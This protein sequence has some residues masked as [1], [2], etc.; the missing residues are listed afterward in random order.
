[1]TEM[2]GGKA[3]AADPASEPSPARTAP[4]RPH[5][6]QAHPL[7]QIALAA[8]RYGLCIAA[9]AWLVTHVPW[10][11]YIQVQDPAIGRI[12]LI[13]ETPE[14]FLVQAADGARRVLTPAEAKTVSVGGLTV[15]DIEYGIPSVVLRMNRQ[16]A[17]L[18]I[19]IFLPVPILSAQRLI[20]ML[21]IQDVRLSLWNSVKLT[22]VGNFFNFALPGTTG[23]DLIK[24]YYL[25]R[26]THRK[27]EA[28]TTIFL[29]RIIGL[30]GLVLLAGALMVTSW[31]EQ[32]FGA[33]ARPLLLV[34]AVLALGATFIFSE[35]M[36]TWLR[37]GDLVRALPAGIGD[38]VRRVGLA[39]IA[40]RH[41][42]SNLAL[43][44]LI[45]AVLQSI[46]MVSAACMAWALDMQG[47]LGYFVVYVAVGFLIAAIPIAPPQAFGVLEYFYVYVFTR[48][49][50]NSASQAV[51]LALA[52]RLIQ[53]VW[54]LPGLLVPLL[55]AHL[56]STR[57]L[58][59]MEAQVEREE[60]ETPW[61]AEGELSS[62]VPPAPTTA[63]RS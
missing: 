18:A 6:R 22:F 31:D 2:S 34:C 9:I 23:G 61:P 45:T 51:A 25:T 12:R 60:L 42:K 55:G 58:A 10:Y 54:S 16:L 4:Q 28:V 37:L 11:D 53:L 13:R 5:P 3:G 48:G 46:V 14:G 41:H 19:L 62:T 35:R 38:Q 50:V 17:L 7:A 59:D 24:A 32:Q 30:L 1:M 20:W 56:P 26:F 52:V 47:S 49:Q 39:T 44:F 29:D 63:E 15:P 8:L 40:L 33:L 57:E 36:R 43:S 21:G 27:T